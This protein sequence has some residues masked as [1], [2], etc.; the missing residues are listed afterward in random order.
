LRVEVLLH[1]VFKVNRVKVGHPVVK[2]GEHGRVRLEPET[3]D[4]GLPG[5]EPSKY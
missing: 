1:A 3:V 5:L 2:E 4:E